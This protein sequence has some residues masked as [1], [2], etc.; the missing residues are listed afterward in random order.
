MEGIIEGFFFDYMDEFELELMVYDER[1]YF[2]SFEELIVEVLIR[3][4]Y[5]YEF[6]I[7]FLYILEGSLL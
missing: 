2:D 3:E 4:K 5:V 1:V 6:Y 7:K